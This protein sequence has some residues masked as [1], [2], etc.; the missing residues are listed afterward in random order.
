MDSLGCWLAH[1]VRRAAAEEGLHCPNVPGAQQRVRLVG[2]L[3]VHLLS[4]L[5]TVAVVLAAARSLSSSRTLHL[6]LQ[7]CTVAAR[8]GC[9]LGSRRLG[10]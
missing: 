9:R 4:E 10:R 5:S 1:G 3:L 2:S 7:P 6:W 8:R